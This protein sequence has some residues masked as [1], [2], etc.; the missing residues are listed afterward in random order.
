MAN[1]SLLYRHTVSV[2]KFD[3]TTNTVT[4]QQTILL[5]QLGDPHPNS[6]KQFISDLIKQIQEWHHAGK[7]FSLAWMPMRMLTIQDLR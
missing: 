2:L 7:K 5:Q 4:A 3:A 6:R 1:T